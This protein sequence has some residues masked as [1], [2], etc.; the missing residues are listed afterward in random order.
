MKTVSIDS[1]LRDIHVEPSRPAMKLAGKYGYLPYMVERYIR[2]LG[3]REAEDLLRSL[4]ERLPP[5]V[6][7]N[8]VLIDPERLRERLEILGFKLDKI[9]W[10]PYS[11]RVLYSPE[12]PSIG[13]THEYLKGY[14]YVHRDAAALIPPI[15]LVE[16]YEGPVLD[17][18][19]AP[20]GKTT[21]LAQLLWGRGRVIANDLVLYRIKSLVGHAMRM[22]LDNIDITWA[23]A[24]KL[25]EILGEKFRRILLDAPCSG[26]GTIMFD[27]GR[28]TRTTIKDLAVIVKREI[29]LLNA[30]LDMLEE[31]GVLAYSTC[32]IAPEENEYVLYRVMMMRNDFEIIRPK[33]K[34]FEWAPWLGSYKDIDFPEEFKRCIRIWPHIHRMM[35]FTVCLL[36]KL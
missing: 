22:K 26:E 15:L 35:G 20:G 1:I 8:T 10:A 34:L 25:P 29:E 31:G 5:V 36:R 30:G 16:D 11:Y 14:Y 27:P 33:K 28:K 18:C 6:R 21:H 9:P 24:R 4:D 12:S 13:S 7:T 19:A 17:M 3:L 23:D 32:S 2:M